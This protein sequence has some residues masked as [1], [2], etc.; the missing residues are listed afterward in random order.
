ML[1]L[2]LGAL[3]SVHFGEPLCLVPGHA[4]FSVHSTIHIRFTDKLRDTPDYSVL[5]PNV[6]NC[7]RELSNAVFKK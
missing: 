4:V 3:F 6:L 1:D 2:P 5:S 7:V